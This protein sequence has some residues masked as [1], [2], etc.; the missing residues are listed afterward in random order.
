[1][2]GRLKI[3]YSSDQHKQKYHTLA[4]G[5]EEERRNP[6]SNN[7]TREAG[8]AGAANNNIYPVAVFGA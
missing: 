6:C 5:I 4:S 3:K 1:M 8:I 7:I 2:N